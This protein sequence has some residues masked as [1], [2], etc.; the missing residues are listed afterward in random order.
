MKPIFV[1]ERKIQCPPHSQFCS[2]WFDFRS[3]PGR[4]GGVD[5]HEEHLLPSL[6]S[7][8]PLG[9]TVEHKQG[10]LSAPFLV[11]L[12]RNVSWAVQRD[13]RRICQPTPQLNPELYC[14]NIQNTQQRQ[15]K[16]FLLQA[17]SAAQLENSI[18]SQS[19]F[20]KSRFCTILL[21]RLLGSSFILIG[22]AL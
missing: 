9:G 11:Y 5:R 21:K 20:P 14:Q 1:R 15:I 19:R 7:G 3:A 2:F 12:R 13:G 6:Y 4:G 22:R 10:L 16:L 18:T 8:V 17:K